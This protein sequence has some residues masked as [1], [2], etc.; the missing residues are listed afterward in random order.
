MVLLNSVTETCSAGEKH[1]L[2]SAPTTSVFSEWPQVREQPL[3]ISSLLKTEH[4]S[5][6]KKCCLFFYL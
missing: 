3:D 5:L 4:C 1:A 6:T 2:F